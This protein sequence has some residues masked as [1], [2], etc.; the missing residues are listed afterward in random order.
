MVG[1]PPFRNVTEGQHAGKLEGPWGGAQ[2]HAL[3]S[4]PF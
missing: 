4:F 1:G 3:K 2:L